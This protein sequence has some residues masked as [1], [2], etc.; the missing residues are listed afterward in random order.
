MELRQLEY[1]VAI[2]ETGSFNQAAERCHVSQ[3]SLSQQII[4]LEKEIGRKLFDRLGRSIALTEVGNVLYPHARSIL[5][6]VQQAKYAVTEGYTVDEGSLQIGMIPTLGPYVLHETVK[7]FQEMYPRVDFGIYEDVTE[8]L[9]QKLLNAELDV[10]Y[11][12]LPINNKQITTEA[13]FVESLYM[14]VPANH[15]LASSDT[16][17]TGKLGN[18]P[19]IRLSDQDCLADQQDTFCYVQKIDPPKI[20]HTTQISTVMEFVRLGVGVSLVPICSAALYSGDDVVFRP[21]S[22]SPAERTIVAAR[23]RGRANSPLIG[24]F[25]NCLQNSWRKITDNLFSTHD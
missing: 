21:I 16:I 18:I 8:N 24:A 9:I 25:N 4:K 22:N 1:F 20:Y 7:S 5:S 6:E 10:A 2:V 11:M 3:P 19:F 12:S 17:E 13:L 15:S 23:H 14:A